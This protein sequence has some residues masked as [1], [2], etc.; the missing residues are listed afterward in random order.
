[1][2]GRTIPMVQIRIVDEAMNDMPHDGIAEAAFIGVPDKK[3]SERPMAVVVVTS[4]LHLTQTEITALCATS[5]T[6]D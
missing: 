1:M 2:T 5:R 4:D 3:C 6:A